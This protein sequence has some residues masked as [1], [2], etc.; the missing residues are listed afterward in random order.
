[1]NT[2][3][4][5]YYSEEHTCFFRSV[6]LWPLSDEYDFFFP[7]WIF[8]ALKLNCFDTR[9]ILLFLLQR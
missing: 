5:V 7:C 6:S 9:E 2:C 3:E 4:C 1:M 8:T